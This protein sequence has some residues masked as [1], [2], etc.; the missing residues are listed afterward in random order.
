MMECGDRVIH[1]TYGFGI[2]KRRSAFTPVDNVRVKFDSRGGIGA[3]LS[4]PFWELEK[5]FD[6]DG[7][8]LSQ[9]LE[10]KVL[11]SKVIGL[12]RQETNTPT[13]HAPA[14]THHELKF[15]PDEGLRIEV[16]FGDDWV[17]HTI[18]KAL[19]EWTF[20]MRFMTVREMLD[21]WDA[22]DLRNESEYFRKE[23]G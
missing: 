6:E 9:E 10:S 18:G 2:V 13:L 15:A 21:E 5:L 17:K 23:I 20:G 14:L 7:N 22:H 4:V 16:E 19:V 3:M 11:E 1:R 8:D 12:G